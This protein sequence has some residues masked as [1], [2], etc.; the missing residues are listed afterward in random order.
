MGRGSLG[1]GLA[2]ALEEGEAHAAL[3]LAAGPWE[4][5]VPEHG[6][7]TC[8]RARACVFTQRLRG[9]RADVDV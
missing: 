8:V 2:L 3:S 9:R 4:R 6:R 5:T 1:L 7:V